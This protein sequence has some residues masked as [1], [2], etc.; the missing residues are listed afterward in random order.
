MVK[1]AVT[2]LISDIVTVQAALPVHAPAQPP[3]V[4]PA[5]G[6]AD[7]VTMVPEV[8]DAVQVEPQ[9]MPAGRLDTAPEPVPPRLTESA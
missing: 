2:L 6:V 7:R 3:K 4:L 9:E 8:N 5:A 1:V